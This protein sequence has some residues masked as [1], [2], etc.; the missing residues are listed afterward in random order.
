VQFG[1]CRQSVV[2]D[3]LVVDG[4]IPVDAYTRLPNKEIKS[5]SRKA[6]SPDGCFLLRKQSMSTRSVGRRQVA[7]DRLRI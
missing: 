4:T 1:K 7:K 6:A 2:A 5:M 3:K